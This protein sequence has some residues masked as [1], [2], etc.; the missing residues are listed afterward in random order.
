MFGLT[1]C[2]DKNHANKVKDGALRPYTTSVDQAKSK[3]IALTF[4]FE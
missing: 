3:I 1:N 4:Y 2:L